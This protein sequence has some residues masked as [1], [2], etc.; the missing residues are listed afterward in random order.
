MFVQ[1]GTLVKRGEIVG[2]SGGQPG[3]KGAGLESASPHLSF[4]ILKN[5]ESVDPYSVL[6]LSIFGDE[7][8]LP[9]EY[10]MKFLQDNLARAVDLTSPPEVKGT[11]L[12]ERRDYFLDRYAS[13]PWNDPALR[14]DGAM[15]TGIDPLFGICIGFAETSFRNFKTS[16]NI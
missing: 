13:R 14:N 8:E 15:Q 9:A 10:R 1:P 12:S 6:D 7:E 5:G 11:T 3:T 2:N 16:N 4:E